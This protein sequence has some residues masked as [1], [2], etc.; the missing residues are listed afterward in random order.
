MAEVNTLEIDQKGRRLDQL[1]HFGQNLLAN[2][3]QLMQLNEQP[4]GF[5]AERS[6]FAAGWSRFAA[7]KKSGQTL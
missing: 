3:E 4:F 1:V 6:R 5:V 7:E 2:F